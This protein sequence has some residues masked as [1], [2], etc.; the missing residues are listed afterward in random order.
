MRMS[1]QVIEALDQASEVR[2][3]TETEVDEVNGGLIFAVLGLVAAFEV[4]FLGGCIAANYSKT[5]NFW[6]DI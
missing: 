3:L 5:G 2:E 4:G 6:G 1:T